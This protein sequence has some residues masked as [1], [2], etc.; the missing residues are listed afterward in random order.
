[1]AE[2]A[3]DEAAL[4]LYAVPPEEFL[5]TRN[6][7]VARARAA[8]DTAA[9]T[10]IGKLRKPTVAAWLVNALVLADDSVVERLGEL[11][12]RLRAAQEQLDAAV[13]RE[14][15]TERRRLVD[16]LT[17]AAFARAKRTQPPA[18]LRDEVSGTF[19]AALADPEVGARLGRLTRA[20]QW[21]GF[22]FL[23]TGAPQLTVVRGGRST[24][25]ERATTAG[26]GTS[27]GGGKSGAGKGGSTEAGAGT[28][29]APAPAKSAAERRKER[30][31]VADAQT[32]LEAAEAALA[33]AREREA[34]SGRRVKQLARRLAKLQDELEGARSS[35]E[36]ARKDVS[37]A[38]GRRREARSALD[39]AQRAARD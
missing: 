32:A 17:R 19:D 12:D 27:S 5:G 35:L 20:E 23:P 7:L 22:G 8:G 10:Q 39:R 33:D 6:D 3:V 28:A 15:T 18:G 25:R 1:V 31:A 4:E 13:L 14:L 21:S 24:G 30:K 37:T 34:D 2:D 29:P 38:K 26:K 9:A 16:E 11:G 36:D